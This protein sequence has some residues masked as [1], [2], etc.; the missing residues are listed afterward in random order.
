[1]KFVVAACL[2]SFLITQHINICAEIDSSSFY[3][4]INIDNWNCR[5]QE[6]K[7]YRE[8][9]T[10]LYK[11][12]YKIWLYQN[13]SLTIIFINLAY[14]GYGLEFLWIGMHPKMLVYGNYFDATGTTKLNISFTSIPNCCHIKM[15]N[16]LVCISVYNLKDYSCTLRTNAH[17]IR[18]IIFL[19]N[20]VVLFFVAADLQL[21][22][23]PL[24]AQIVQNSIL[25]AFSLFYFAFLQLNHLYNLIQLL[26][27]YKDCDRE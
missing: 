15:H 10:K 20:W 6:I 16:N 27:K 4:I 25:I 14:L 18:I 23:C 5:L 2:S 19:K 21:H 12:K 22:H 9:K 11:L 7:V 26:Q 1:M 3:W 17:N 24:H 8:H 13:I